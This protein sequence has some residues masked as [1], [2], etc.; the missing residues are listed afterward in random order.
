MR[1]LL[2][3]LC[4]VQFTT[5]CFSQNNNQDTLIIQTKTIRIINSNWGGR[6]NLGISSYN[7]GEKTS[8]W[9]GNHGGPDFNLAVCYKDFRFGF[10]F[11]PW[12]VNPKSELIFNNDTLTTFAKINPLKFE[13][14]VGYNLSELQYINIEP[15]IGFV[16]NSFVVINED[17]LHTKYD[18]PTEN[19]LT[20]GLSIYKPIFEYDP[21]ESLQLFINSNINLVNFANINTNLDKNFWSFEIGLS[22]QG[23][24]TKKEILK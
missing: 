22:Y 3:L 1:R 15:Y 9:L 21:F 12:T 24:F 13:F 2:L 20:L 6:F 17:V 4:L 7:Y 19:G 23:W 14:L 16:T 11:K 5:V 8:A 10:G 18:I